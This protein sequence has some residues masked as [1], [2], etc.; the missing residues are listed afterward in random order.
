VAKTIKPGTKG[1]I[2]LAQFM[3]TPEFLACADKQRRWLQTL[4]ESG[5]NYELANATAFAH[6]TPRRALLYGY[7]VR[8]QPH[9]VA[10][11][12]VYLETT[13]ADELKAR[14]QESVHQLLRQVRFQLR[15]AELGSVAA[16][17][18]LS[19]EERLLLGGRLKVE[20]DDEPA[21][22]KQTLPTPTVSTN[23][24]PPSCR[25]VRD[26]ETFELK[27]YLQPDG[28]FVPLAPVEVVR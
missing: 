12:Q 13:E 25:P 19:Q 8:R 9:V 28:T 11:L 7:A 22:E 27:G 5:F 4:V 1:V 10:A 16:Q 20:D 26:R 14:R 24:V 18:L 3:T 17:R 6:L 23:R 15:H 2:T 21:A